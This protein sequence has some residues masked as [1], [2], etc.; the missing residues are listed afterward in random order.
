MFL[1]KGLKETT[2]FIDYQGVRFISL[3]SNIAIEEQNHGFEKTSRN[4]NRWTILTFHHP[5][6]SPASSRD[7]VAI[8]EQWKPILDEFRVDL[9]F[10]GMITAIQERDF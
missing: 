6:Y 4:P 5:L 9:V 2:Y 1:T 3:D 8:R 7:N 10:S